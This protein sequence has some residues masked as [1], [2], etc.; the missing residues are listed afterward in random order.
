LTVVANGEANVAQRTVASASPGLPWGRPVVTGILLLIVIAGIGAG[1]PAVVGRGPWHQHAVA[2]GVGLEILLAGLQVALVI[3]ARRPAAAGHPAE[4]LR[5]ALR[6]VVA[7]MMI[8]IVVIAIANF[9]GNK[10]GSLVQRLLSGNHKAQRRKPAKL[11]PG[12]RPSTVNH[13]AGYLLY[14]L[15]GVVVLAAIVVCVVLVVRA[16]ARLRRSGGYVDDAPADETE[17]LR[18]AVVSGRAALRTLDDARAAIIACYVAM[19]DSLASAGAAKAAAETPDELLTRAV[20]A[21]VIRRPAAARLTTLF[22]EARFSTHP[23][24]ADAKDAARQALDVISAELDGDTVPA[25]QRAEGPI[26]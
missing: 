20:A 4:A 9:I 16:H 26:R 6:W 14:G 8:F 3:M 15:I 7:V 2:I 22:Y 21:G 5:Q 23:V 13:A 25:G 11:P 19:E 10:H 17:D 12:I 18:Q 1:S 24:A